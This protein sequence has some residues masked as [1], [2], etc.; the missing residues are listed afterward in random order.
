MPV[1]G[2]PGLTTCTENQKSSPLVMLGLFLSFVLCLGAVTALKIGI[3]SCCIKCCPCC[4]VE[5][6]QQY[7]L[8]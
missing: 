6:K 4:R 2:W 3:A 5:E 8:A 1:L 7:E